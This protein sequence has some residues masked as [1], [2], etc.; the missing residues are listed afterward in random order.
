MT[1]KQV[2]ELNITATP[3]QP[4]APLRRLGVESESNSAFR[5]FF[6]TLV[7]VYGMIVTG[8]N[9]NSSV[10]TVNEM[11]RLLVERD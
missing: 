8:K 5:D 4:E 3:M 1:N 6:A 10:E 7:V 11:M 9:Q 2:K